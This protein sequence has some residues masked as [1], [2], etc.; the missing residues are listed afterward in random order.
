MRGFASDNNAGIHP[1]IL[2]AINNANIDHV[3]SYGDDIYTAKAIELFRK[4]FGQQAEIFFVFNGTAANTL[5]LTHTTQSFN[6]VICA[7]TA[8]IH[9]DECGAPESMAGI[10]LITLPNRHG[11]ITTTDI[12]P[13]LEVF[14]FEHHSQP[15]AVSISQTTEMGTVYTP[16][17]IKTLAEF[18]HSYNMILHVDGARIANAAA[19]LSL[20]FEAFTTDCGVDVISFGGTKN[21]M[22]IGEAVV[23]LNSKLS[24]NFKYRRKQTMQLFS[25]MRFVSAQFLA[26]FEN[27]LW[28]QNANK[29]NKMAQVLAS[30]IRQI[31]QI[32]I[33]V[34][35]E[36][37]GVFAKIPH[38]WI[39]PLQKEF[40]FY[41]WDHSQDIV[42][43]MCSFDTTNE[44]INRF[45]NLLKEFAKRE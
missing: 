4:H 29:A 30:E 8:H 6:S 32:K 36:A 25:K 43:W 26:Y 34:P 9:I 11:K 28:L 33:I 45:V 37:N 17:E 38:A 22:M 10:K 3:T 12:Q 7:D 15:A 19:A 2:S 31:P 41:M 5:G 35:V 40:S 16:A 24:Q 18:A 20:P 23:F 13:H 44:D 42:R 14:G 39:E 27:D 1:Q 21:G